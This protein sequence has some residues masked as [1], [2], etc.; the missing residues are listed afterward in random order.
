MKLV[1]RS[2]FIMHFI[3]NIVLIVAT[4]GLAPFTS[5]VNEYI[6]FRSTPIGVSEHIHNSTVSLLVLIFTG[7]VIFFSI[8]TDA[9]EMSRVNV[10]WL[11]DITFVKIFKCHSS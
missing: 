9:R 2:L 5:R 3:V 8:C 1:H 6:D 7:N 10:V 4:W 11:Y